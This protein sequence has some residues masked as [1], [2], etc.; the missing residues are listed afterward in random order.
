MFCVLI[1]PTSLVQAV[2]ISTFSANGQLFSTCTLLYTCTHVC[3]PLPL[4]LPVKPSWLCCCSRDGVVDKKRDLFLDSDKLL[5]TISG[6]DYYYFV[7]ERIQL[8]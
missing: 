7:S 2:A 5:T 1:L 8:S 4:L 3:T 6:W